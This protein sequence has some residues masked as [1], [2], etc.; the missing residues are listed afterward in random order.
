[1][2]IL[3][4]DGWHKGFIIAALKATVFD[5]LKLKGAWEAVMR[6]SWIVVK[7]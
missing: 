3:F 2:Y 6:L 7:I 5:E 4:G 1:M